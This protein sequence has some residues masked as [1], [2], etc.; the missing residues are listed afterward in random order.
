MTPLRSTQLEG[1]RKKYTPIDLLDNPELQFTGVQS[2]QVYS[3]RV[4][5]MYSGPYKTT[6][7]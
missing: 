7:P 4:H 2:E 5:R 3:S 1:R 6:L